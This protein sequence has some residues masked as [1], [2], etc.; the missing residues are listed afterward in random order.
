MAEPH[1]APAT[2][3]VATTNKGLK[4]MA[5]KKTVKAKKPAV[6]KP[7][8]AQA[9]AKI[10]K[11]KKQFEGGVRAEFCKAIPASGATLEQIAKKAGVDFKKALGYAR[12]LAANGYL[13]R[14]EAAKS[15]GV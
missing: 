10:Y 8:G 12:W 11:V 4:N 2:Q 1:T 5:T 6:T 13:I 9:L 15:K 3:P 7:A 14:V